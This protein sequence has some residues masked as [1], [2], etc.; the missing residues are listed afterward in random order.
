MKMETEDAERIATLLEVIHQSSK[1]FGHVE[2]DDD[3]RQDLLR[4]RSCAVRDLSE[5]AE[6]LKRTG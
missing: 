3:F 5:M 6:D 4:V 2:D 1:L